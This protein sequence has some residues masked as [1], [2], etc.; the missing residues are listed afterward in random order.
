MQIGPSGGNVLFTFEVE[1][2]GHCRLVVSLSGHTQLG[3]FFAGDG[4]DQV[5][6][7]PPGDHVLEWTFIAHHAETTESADRAIIWVRT[8]A[9]RFP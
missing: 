4:D 2:T 1:C 6:Q 9:C 5:Y 7:L 3:E 8:D